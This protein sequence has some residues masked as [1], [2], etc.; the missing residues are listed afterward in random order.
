MTVDNRKLFANRDARRR[1]AE[2]GGIMASSPELLGEA[3]KFN[4]GGRV[5]PGTVFQEEGPGRTM[6]GQSTLDQL[7]GDSPTLRA[8]ALSRIGGNIGEF[9]NEVGIDAIRQADALYASSVSL[10]ARTAAG[11]TAALGALASVLG[12]P[13]AG[14]MMERVSTD[15]SR[16]RENMMRG[17]SE[18][19]PFGLEG[20]R[21]LTRGQED[22]G[23]IV[24]QEGRNMIQAAETLR[25]LEGTPEGAGLFAEGSVSEPLSG[26][27]TLL[28]G[29]KGPSPAAPMMMDIA[30]MT[31]PAAGELGVAPSAMDEGII[32]RTA[33]ALSQRGVPLEP[34]PDMT[35]MDSVGGSRVSPGGRTMALPS[36]PM[37]AADIE[38]QLFRDRL[39][40]A[41][42][43]YV[44]PEIP[45]RFP[46][47]ERIAE[48]RMNQSRRD[49]RPMT[50]QQM[51]EAE[52]TARANEEMDRLTRESAEEAAAVRSASGVR[53]AR[54]SMGAAIAEGR[55]EDAARIA[56]AAREAVSPTPP[57]V[58]S[59]P[60][61]KDLEE[62]ATNPDL[63]PE[64][65]AEQVASGVLGGLGVS[66][67]DKMTAAERVKAYE[68]MFKEMLGEGE[69]DKQKEMWH[70][71][72][73]IGFAI[74]A[75]E[76][77]RALQNIAN[78]LL[79]GTKMMKDDRATRQAREDKI[80]MLAI[81]EGMSDQRA[82][83]KARADKEIAQI[84]AGSSGYTSTR[85]RSRLKEL[86]MKDAW[87]YPGLLGDNGQIDPDKLNDYLDTIVGV[88]SEPL[89]QE[90]AVA[91]Y[92]QLIAQR[93][94][95]K[96]AALN[97]LKANGYNIEG[98]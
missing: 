9:I 31:P 58:P 12:F 72:A 14:A 98:L 45:D 82:A 29:S 35:V 63:T 4:N 16:G 2:M 64:Q 20:P 54:D 50:S 70:N 75:G 49:Y 93:P 3:Q 6:P 44:T 59:G 40:L 96:E 48:D 36:D 10:G 7:V 77:P 15:I 39:G 34:G 94:D 28:P 87:S 19:M 60:D 79:A 32:S 67:A 97:R 57:A 86:I 65:K 84:R 1:L 76:S 5:I 61:L 52:R 55:P 53:D 85:E 51:A 21:L 17:D 46:G 23:F 11:G 42:D 18:R 80:K 43:G 68:T 13:D 74:A 92:N 71:M 91:Q 89:T 83:E 38:A 22:P 24:P 30:G 25:T 33:P 90:Q 69:E 66:G 88:E 41:T 56:E 37:S 73:M 95:L 81:S 8:L 47:E 62:T 27:Y 26:E 78:G